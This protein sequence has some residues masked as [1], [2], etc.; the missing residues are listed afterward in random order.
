MWDFGS[1]GTKV[2]MPQRSFSEKKMRRTG[3]L[4]DISL[5]FFP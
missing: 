3:T 5:V 4:V 2:P 1:D